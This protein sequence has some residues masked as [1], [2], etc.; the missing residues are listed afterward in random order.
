MKTIHAGPVDS[1]TVTQ[2]G[3]PYICVE[4]NPRGFAFLRPEEARELA[5]TLYE[6]ADKHAQP[7][8]SHDDRQLSLLSGEK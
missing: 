1:I 6:M 5:D 4:L 8:W 7:M 2:A 3:G